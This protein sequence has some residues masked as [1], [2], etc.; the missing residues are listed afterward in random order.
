M[1]EK[2]IWSTIGIRVGDLIE[3]EDNPV[4]LSKHDAEEIL[5]SLDKFNQV[6]PLVANALE[7]DGRRRLIDGHQR[8]H[9]MAA[10]GRW[11]PDTVVNASV[12]SRK[13]TKKECEE[14]AIRIRRNRGAF[15]MDKLANRFDMA[16]LLNYGFMEDELV[17]TDIKT[18]RLAETQVEIRPLPMIRVLV[19]IPVDSA[20]DAKPLLD[21]LAGVPGVEV[22]YGANDAKEGEDA[23]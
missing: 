17:G 4:E 14:V 12:P 21:Q 1:A 3:W 16:D 20:L 2:P 11:G 18:P 5:K 13:L 22:L 7:T 23:F 8:I 6:V 15:D 10:A 19:S 9:V